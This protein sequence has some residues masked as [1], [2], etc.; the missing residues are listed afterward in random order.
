[1]VAVKERRSGLPDCLRSVIFAICFACDPVS[2][3]HGTVR[4]PTDGCPTRPNQGVVDAEVR[5]ICQNLQERSAEPNPSHSDDK[6]EFAF[7]MASFDNFSKN[8]RVRVVKSGYQP[9]EAS[10]GD[11]NS[12]IGPEPITAHVDV[13]LRRGSSP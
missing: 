13:S 5:L 11:L 12:R 8:C 2:T 3:L 6:G 9:F 4:T 10:I 1:M 7:H